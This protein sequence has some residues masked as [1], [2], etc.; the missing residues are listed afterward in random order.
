MTLCLADIA[1]STLAEA[2][3]TLTSAGRALG[4]AAVRVRTAGEVVAVRLGG[5]DGANTGAPC[6]GDAASGLVWVR[7]ATGSLF[8]GLVADAVGFARGTL[9]SGFAGT[10][11]SA[12]KPTDKV[13]LTCGIGSDGVDQDA[14]ASACTASDNRANLTIAGVIAPVINKP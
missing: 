8:T 14:S 10:A 7:S 1:G 2:L 11:V 3:A 5:V 4:V 6:C 9:V 13:A 12:A